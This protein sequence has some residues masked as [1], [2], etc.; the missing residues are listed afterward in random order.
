MANAGFAAPG[1]PPPGGVWSTGLCD[2]ADDADS[3][4]LT[5]FCPC[6]TFGRIATIVDQGATWGWRRRRPWTNQACCAMGTVYALLAPELSFLCS[7]C[8]RSKL[9]TNY[10]LAAEPCVDCCVHLWCEPCALCQEYR[11]LQYR[12]F[13]M[14]IGWHKNM[15]RLGKG[16]T[17]TAPPQ[18]YAGM[19]R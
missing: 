10:G 15:E 8:Y 2:C 6:V 3:C 9:R 16:G 7:C 5:F 4:C 12:G 18:T 14:A 19:Y 13:N 11:E 17:T 1:N